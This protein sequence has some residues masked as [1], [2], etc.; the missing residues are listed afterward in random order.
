[1][2]AVTACTVVTMADHPPT[3][4]VA[5][6]IV[7]MLR[8]REITPYELGKRAGLSSSS[9]VSMILQRGARR[10]ASDTLRRIAAGLGVREL[11][12]LTG[13]GPRDVQA[14]DGTASDAT[15]GVSSGKMKDRPNF[16]GCLSVARTQ[17][18]QYRAYLWR[19]I[20]EGDPIVTVPLTPAML[21][22]LADLLVKYIPD[23][24]D[25]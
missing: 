14:D 2:I 12:L 9:H 20:E 18:P 8:V 25:E 7:E 19:A 13:N 22:D 6:R 15:P 24:G 11:W 16:Y 4:P 21:V 5:Q 17:R 23:P 10:T 3:D 1:M